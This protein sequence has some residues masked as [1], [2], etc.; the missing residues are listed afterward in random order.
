M[1]K[2]LFFI[3]LLPVWC[4]AQTN[5]AP[6]FK[7]NIPADSLL[8]Y[9]IPGINGNH[10]LPD[11]N[12]VK[13]HGG[14]DL[15]SK[16]TDFEGVGTTSDK[17]GLRDTLLKS[18]WVIA[19]GD[20]LNPALT[21]VQKGS[22]PG[23]RIENGENVD[24][25][26]VIWYI[27]TK[28]SKFFEVGVNS[29]GLNHDY[30][31]RNVNGAITPAV[32]FIMTIDTDITR[33]YHPVIFSGQ[34]TAST[35]D[36]VWGVKNDTLVKVP[37]SSSSGTVTS[38]TPGIG[39]T[40]HTPIT[41][42]GTMNVDT[43][44]TIA[45]L[46]YA[47]T[48][49]GPDGVVTG[50]SPVTV[51]GTTATVPS[52]TYRLNNTLITKGS[53]TNVTIDPQDATSDRIDLIVGDASGVLSKVS[54]SLA[55]T[56]AQPDVP[57]NKALISWVYIP[58]TGGTVTTG[59]GGSTKGTVTT[60]KGVNAN[61]FTF[62]IVNP[63]TTPTITL[64]LQNA[65]ASQSGQLTSTD[66]NTFNNKQSA[67]TF[68]T[69]L[70]NNSG[71]VKGDTTVLQT[72]A[73]FF[74]KGDTRYYKASNPSG[75]ISTISGIAAGGDLTGTYP[76]PTLA[77]TAVTA[78]SYTN[79]NIT[80]DAKGRITAAA[81]GSGGGLASSNFVYGEVPSGSINST[82]VTYTLAN[83][84]T[85]GTVNVFLN[86]NRQTITTNYTISGSTITF[87]FPPQTGDVIAINYMK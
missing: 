32:D 73:N 24:G 9:S 40:S 10:W 72:I 85:S 44:S 31:I 87:T 81:N 75:Y 74:P 82:N 71:T 18:H 38:I 15:I 56:P 68:S 50:M 53:S 6:Q 66:W 30:A 46:Y 8:G 84:P 48:I 83:T 23:L 58:A 79:A 21:L 25:R 11:T 62:S 65:T 39:F 26:S 34:R 67:L 3:F 54:G 22:Q 60:V 52:G 47:S 14:Q 61:G 37:F 42:V 36:S 57:S 7:R 16:A 86:G 1:K 5:F 28:G 70:I 80:V 45:T 4:F 13:K 20:V 78:G 64:A 55:A 76:N 43:V 59:G 33:W 2:L 63:T 12:W 29:A 27:S 49:V 17:F 41:S 51:S 69:G 77:N 35:A 19:S